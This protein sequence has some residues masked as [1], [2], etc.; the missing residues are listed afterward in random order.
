MG[1]PK[2]SAPLSAVT[3]NYELNALS[4][5][6]SVP[7]LDR[8]SAAMRRYTYTYL[9]P[10]GALCEKEQIAPASPTFE[11]A[12]SA[13][14][15]GTLLSTP[16]GPVAIQD[17]VPGMEVTSQDGDACR[18]R[19]IGSITIAPRQNPADTA[20]PSGLF[21][22]IPDAFGLGRPAGNLLM[23]PGA[24]L[25]TR[26]HNLRESRSHGSMF[27][28][29]SD[30]VDGVNVIGVSPPMRVTVFHLILDRHAILLADGLETESYHPGPGFDRMMDAQPRQTFLSLFPQMRTAEEIGDIACARL[31]LRGV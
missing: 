6:A 17:L 2:L 10:D 3:Q 23:G 22:V 4:G 9:R 27:T 30:L 14:A 28:P 16:E 15:H 13:F 12:F 5:R 29:C 31:P 19:W 18:I 26:P 20:A 7:R 24:R 25:L 8:T 21:R 11:A 1:T